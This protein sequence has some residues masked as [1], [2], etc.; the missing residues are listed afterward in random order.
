M[1]KF[2]K[3]PF[4]NLIEVRLSCGQEFLLDEAV[5]VHMCIDMFETK[6]RGKDFKYREDFQAAW[7]E[8]M[9]SSNDEYFF[10]H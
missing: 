8:Y 4:P 3:I 6:T 10:T 7:A 9:Y 2:L 5:F 1:D